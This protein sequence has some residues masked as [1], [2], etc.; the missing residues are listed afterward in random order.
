M[1]NVEFDNPHL[2]HTV[3]LT[4]GILL[5]CAYGYWRR[6]AVLRRFADLG[7]IGSVAPKLGWVRPV[8]RS[9]TLAIAVL[10]LAIA[11][12]GPRWGEEES[13]SFQRNIDLMILLDVSRSMLAED[14][15]PNRLERAKVAISDDLLPALGGD[16]VG[17]ITFAGEVEVT[18]PLTT[19]YGYFRLQ[20]ADVSPETVTRGGTLIGDAIR[21][22]AELFDSP[23]EANRL[24]LLITDGEDH[25]SF[26]LE[27]A[28]AAWN[29]ADIPIISVALGD[30]TQPATIPI[31]NR[32]GRRDL[33]RKDG[34]IVRTQ[35][36]DETLRQIAQLSD[37]HAVLPVGVRNFDLGALYVEQIVPAIRAATR[38]E[39]TLAPDKPA[40]YAMFAWMALLLLLL[41]PLLR[42]F[43]RRASHTHAP[44]SAQPASSTQP[45][46]ATRSTLTTQGVTA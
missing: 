38:A 12:S 1:N 42:D 40:R 45:E 22:A 3:W 18:C 30:P 10:M 6:R 39:E 46:R 26:P 11:A 32:L 31:R 35:A 43:P 24:I 20:L 8:V 28:T 29:D 34:E 41:E 17:L 25:A 23:I 4:L 37:L 13:T 36:R 2:L 14:L 9:L 7:L 5:I 27:A 21:R 19:D 15:A 44:S 33:L 16:R